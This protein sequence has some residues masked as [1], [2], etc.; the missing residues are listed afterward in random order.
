MKEISTSIEPDKL[1][2]YGCGHLVRY[3]RRITGTRTVSVFS[4]TGLLNFRL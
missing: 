3:N 2:N 4:V 1:G